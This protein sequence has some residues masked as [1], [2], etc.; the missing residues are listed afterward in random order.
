[1]TS[2]VDNQ[3]SSSKKY[4]EIFSKYS[5]YF[6]ATPLVLVLF[7]FAFIPI[8]II[9]MYSVYEFNGFVT[10]PA[11]TFASYVEI[12][13]DWTSLLNLWHTT[14]I[15]AITWVITLVLGFVISYF[16]VFDLISFRVKVFFFLLTVVPFWTSGVVR[17]IAWVPFLGTEGVLNSSLLAI[18][19]VDKPLQMLLF[20][21]FAVIMSYV[22]MFT[23]FMVAPLFNVMARINPNLIEAAKDQG[24]KGWQILLYI[25]IPMTKPGIV[26]GTIFIV[27]MTATDFTAIRILSGAKSGSIAN[28]IS[29]DYFNAFY[30]P[31]AAKSVILLIILLLFVGGL[32]RIVDIRKQ[33]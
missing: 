26:I 19:I 12:F 13:T 20:S 22:H 1:M 27:A 33:M 25:I 29:V 6:Q 31:A 16:L 15:F 18:G 32:M 21:E 8:L 24:A 4:T 23:L 30:P 10:L 5:A 2:Q 7:V 28:N 3:N 11:F 14:R 9:F 17:M